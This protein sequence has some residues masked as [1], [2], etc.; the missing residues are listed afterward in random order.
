MLHSF[1]IFTDL[2]FN[3]LLLQMS[4]YSTINVTS[5]SKTFFF[6]SPSTNHFFSMKHGFLSKCLLE[7]LKQQYKKK[8]NVK[9]KLTNNRTLSLRKKILIDSK[10]VSLQQHS[11]VIFISLVY[12][13]I[14]Y[15]L[16]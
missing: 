12:F 2:F 8:T 6:V 5:T 14:M 1:L 9:L 11:T 16:S 4:L 15:F 7:I 3:P 13:I 10:Y